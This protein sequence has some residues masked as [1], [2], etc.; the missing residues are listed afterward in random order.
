MMSEYRVSE[1]VRFE[2]TK[3]SEQNFP[4]EVQEYIKEVIDRAVHE[5][6]Y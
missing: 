2:L 1:W 5:L 4:H 3:L 6:R